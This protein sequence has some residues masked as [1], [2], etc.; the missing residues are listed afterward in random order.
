MDKSIFMNLTEIPENADL[1]FPLGNTYQ[2]W[3]EIRDFVIEKYPSAIE[4]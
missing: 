4:E 2:Y 1:E 3:K